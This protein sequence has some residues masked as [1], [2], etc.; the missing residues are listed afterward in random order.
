VTREELLGWNFMAGV[1]RVQIASPKDN[2]A[3]PSILSQRAAAS[4]PHPVQYCSV[5]DV[6]IRFGRGKRDKVT[7][8]IFCI[9]ELIA[10]G[11]TS[12]QV[13]IDMHA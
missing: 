11:P 12:G 1:F 13:G 5:T 10:D 9:P 6:C 2:G 4:T 7:K 3:Q 8:D